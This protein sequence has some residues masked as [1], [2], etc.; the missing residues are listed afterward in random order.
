M[1]TFIVI[2]WAWETHLNRFEWVKRKEREPSN[3]G[4]FCTLSRLLFTKNPFEV[5]AHVIDG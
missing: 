3:Q 4:L 5:G 1:E 2:I